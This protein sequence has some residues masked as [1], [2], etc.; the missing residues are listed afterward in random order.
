MA[1][2]GLSK[3][4]QGFSRSLQGFGGGGEIGIAI[5]YPYLDI[6]QLFSKSGDVGISIGPTPA[7][8]ALASYKKRLYVAGGNGVYVYD[9]TGDEIDAF[10]PVPPPN[11]S[12]CIDV[13]EDIV[14]VDDSSS[15]PAGG[16]AQMRILELDGTPI[17]DFGFDGT[18][19]GPLVVIKAV[20]I[21]DSE[22]YCL[23]TYL[24]RILVFNTSGVFQR[25]FGS[26]GTG[27]G[28]L[29]SAFGIDAFNSEIYIAD[30]GNNR[31][32]VFSK[33]GTF[34]RKW[35][36]SGTEEGQFGFVAAVAVDSSGVY[37]L[38]D[39]YNKVSVFGHNGTFIK[40]WNG[41]GAIE[42]GMTIF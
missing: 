42:E 33:S 34:M 31:I 26:A 27:D 12:N 32:Q 16:T 40:R 25:S 1:L 22:I 29:V 13:N 14:V 5:F 10:T 2:Q 21:Y 36:S 8:G 37:V 41:L 17:L 35:G 30:G 39:V 11:G 28:Q 9:K 19:S 4:L 6:T 3:N 15:A 23:D 7:L 20:V 38:D 24:D 18:G